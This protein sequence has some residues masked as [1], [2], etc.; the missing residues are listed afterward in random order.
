[1]AALNYPDH[2]FVA[3]SGPERAQLEGWLNFYRDTLLVK[4]DGLSDDQLRL[5]PVASSTLSLLGLLRHLTFVEVLWF[6]VRFSGLDT[7]LPYGRDN[8]QSSDFTDLHDTPL[9]TVLSNFEATRQR[10]DALVAS[11]RLDELSVGDRSGAERVDLRWIYLHLIE[12]YARHLGH[13]DL[14]RELIDGRVGY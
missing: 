11:R 4:C 8:D 1:M 2:R 7:P 5:Q 14:L 3:P 9:E 10:V 6:E 13:A 12:E